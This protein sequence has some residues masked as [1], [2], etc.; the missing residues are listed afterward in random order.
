MLLDQRLAH[1]TEHQTAGHAL[2]RHTDTHALTGTHPVVVH[3]GLQTDTLQPVTTT[4]LQF[5]QHHFTVHQ[6]QQVGYLLDT[7]RLSLRQ[8]PGL[9]VQWCKCIVGRTGYGDTALESVGVVVHHT[10]EGI[11]CSAHRH[12]PQQ[13]FDVYIDGIHTLGPAFI[14]GAVIA[15]AQHHREVTHR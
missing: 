5:R 6:R 3:H 13:V 15:L 1:L 7:L 12:V 8:H 2:G 14:L 11:R 4:C 9:F 10:I